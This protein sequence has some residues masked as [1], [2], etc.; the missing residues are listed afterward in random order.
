MKLEAENKKK[1]E[2]LLS[3]ELELNKYKVDEKKNNKMIQEKEDN[4]IKYLQQ[5]SLLQDELENIKNA[6][7]KE[8]DQEVNNKI[9]KLQLDNNDLKIEK[10]ELNMKNKENLSQISQ[11]NRQL[12]DM[13]VYSSSEELVCYNAIWSKARI[14]QHEKQIQ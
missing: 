5:I 1:S 10:E 6:K 8:N 7:Q 3:L 14:S 13:K 12:E 4:L 9:E 11:L 2:K